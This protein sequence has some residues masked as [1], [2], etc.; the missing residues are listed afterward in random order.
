MTQYE[1]L[2]KSSVEEP[3]YTVAQAM[4]L[5]GYTATKF[6]YE[7][8]KIELDRRG[9]DVSERIWRIPRKALVEMGWLDPAT[10][11][12]DE[13][14][15]DVVSPPIRRSTARIIELAERVTALENELSVAQAVI[16]AKDAEIANLSSLLR[17]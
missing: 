11:D 8:N 7:P 1:F 4:R 3:Y 17:K 14:E 6:R 5:T 16:K 2:P 15:Q 12:I 13:L 9:A 10:P